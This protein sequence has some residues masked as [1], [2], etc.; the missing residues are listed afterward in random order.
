MVGTS[1]SSVYAT[2]RDL[3]IISVLSGILTAALELSS[4]RQQGTNVIVNV[5]IR[6][7]NGD[8]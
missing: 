4:A 1:H 8:S 6:A 2:S 5:H 7:L 3:T